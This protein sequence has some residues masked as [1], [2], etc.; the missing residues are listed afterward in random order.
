MQHA[1]TVHQDVHRPD[2]VFDGAGAVVETL[3]VANIGYPWLAVDF[4]R[5]RVRP[6]LVAVEHDDRRARLR[7]H[8]AT[9]GA[10]AARAAGHDGD[11]LDP[12]ALPLR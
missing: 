7:Q 4:G 12:H 11:F 2:G 1:G 6:R 8:T 9:G 10:D 5:H 3:L